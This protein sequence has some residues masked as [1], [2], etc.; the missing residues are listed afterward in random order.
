[1]LAGILGLVMRPKNERVAFSF[2]SPCDYA[3]LA[4]LLWIVYTTGSYFD[5][6]KEIFPFAVFYFLTKYVLDTPQKLNGFL[7]C[8][9]I[10]LFVVAFFAL[11]TEWGFEIAE[12]SSD[13]TAMFDGRLALNTWIFNNPNSLGHG[14]VALIPLSYAV[15]WW[16]RPVSNKLLAVSAIAAAGYCVFLTQSKGA[17]LCGFAAF[18]AVYLFRKR[19]VVQ[20]IALSLALTSGVAAI[21]LLPR[22][23]TMNAQ[24][25]GI[26]GRLVIWQMAH[27]AMTNT[28]TGE[29][30]KKFEAWVTIPKVGTVRK[31]THGS[32]VNIGADLG[33]PGLF[34]FLAI[35]YANGRTVLLSRPPDDEL[36]SQQNQKALLS[37]LCSYSA[38]AWM[39][40]RAYH[41]DFF[42]IAGAIAAYHHHMTAGVVRRGTAAKDDAQGANEAGAA[43]GLI[44]GSFIPLP[45]LPGLAAAP[46]HA[47]TFFTAP[48]FEK[49]MQPTVGDMLKPRSSAD[50][51]GDEGGVSFLNW[52]RFTLLDGVL[53]YLLFEAVQYVWVEIMTNFVSF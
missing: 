50:G 2:S 30:W 33:Y 29:G 44:A 53:I 12:G 23:D 37:L 40:D 47:A 51:A 9:C 43:R 28:K 49:N 14:V 27:G 1:M 16:K 3:I 6:F 24:E 15:F 13:L 39:I 5:T 38:S 41:T 32:Y 22:M 17:Y 7:R 31:A 11:T 36:L 8:W 21:K 35:L 25:D 52:K 48:A 18:C 45:A 4:Y 34:L 10:G 26:A 20:V 46:A 19:L 42:F